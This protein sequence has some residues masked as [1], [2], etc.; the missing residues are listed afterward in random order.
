MNN[1]DRGY[2]STVYSQIESQFSDSMPNL[3][4]ISFLEEALDNVKKGKFVGLQKSRL[5]NLTPEQM[6]QGVRPETIDETLSFD[7]NKEEQKTTQSI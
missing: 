1:L 5:Q 4:R 2:S 6:E 3:S 7:L